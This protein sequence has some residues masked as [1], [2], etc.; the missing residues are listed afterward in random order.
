MRAKTSRRSMTN[1]SRPV[2]HC[3]L[4]RCPPMCQCPKVRTD[5]TRNQ[6]RNSIISKIPKFPSKLLLRRAKTSRRFMT[7]ISRPVLHCLL[8]RCPPMCQCPNVRTDQ[9]RN[10]PSRS[11][12]SNLSHEE[13]TSLPKTSLGFFM[14]APLT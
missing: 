3:L 8:C 12:F 4:C 13:M 2:P 5:Q 14:D 6:T 9:T 7:N 1:I 10:S 11:K